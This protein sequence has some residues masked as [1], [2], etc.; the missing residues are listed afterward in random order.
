M[1]RKVLQ[2]CR[3]NHN[4]EHER[5]RARGHGHGHG[6]GTGTTGEGTAPL[7]K[8]TGKGGDLLGCGVRNTITLSRYY[9]IVLYMLGVLAS[10]RAGVLVL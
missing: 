5:E 1:G 10:W 4:D 8:G 3:G 7:R 6:K 2:I 9:A